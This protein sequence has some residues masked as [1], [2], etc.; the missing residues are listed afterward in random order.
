MGSIKKAAQNR[1]VL[2]REN[3]LGPRLFYAVRP[4]FA[5]ECVSL[6][7]PALMLLTCY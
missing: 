2:I 7:R 6:G 4:C 1:K 3:I 5:A